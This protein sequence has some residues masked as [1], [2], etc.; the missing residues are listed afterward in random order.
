VDSPD[1][2]ASFA[3]KFNRDFAHAILVAHFL[4]KAVSPFAHATPGLGILGPAGYQFDNEV[5]PNYWT[6]N[7]LVLV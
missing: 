2:T 7:W 6:S 3:D 5:D 1:W 4:S